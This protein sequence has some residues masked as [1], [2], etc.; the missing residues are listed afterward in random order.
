MDF[1]TLTPTAL[2]SA[3]ALAR[4]HGSARDALQQLGLDLKDVERFEGLSE[5]FGRLLAERNP[6]E[7][8]SEALALGMVAGRVAHRPRA[9][10][11]VDPSSFLMDPDLLVRDAEGESILRL[12]WFEEDLFVGRQL[13]D[14][15]EMPSHV[16]LLC[17]ANYRAGLAGERGRFRF[18]SYGHSYQVES[19]PVRDEDGRVTAVLGIATPAPA[20]AGRLA[21]A[22]ALD[23][24]AERLERTAEVADEHAALYLATGDSEAEAREREAAARARRAA[25]QARSDAHRHRSD[26]GRRL[27]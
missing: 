4:E 6:G 15:S 17:V 26:W 11:S 12:P 27:R 18:T 5:D 22:E 20:P 2:L 8:L 16:R 14:I 19:V 1:D 25:H 10:R 21:A 9:R 3:L 24:R 23:R 7:A 13:P